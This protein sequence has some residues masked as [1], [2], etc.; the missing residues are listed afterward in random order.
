MTIKTQIIGVAIIIVSLVVL[1][2]QNPVKK[3]TLARLQILDITE[4]Y[5]EVRAGEHVGRLYNEFV[6]DFSETDF[7]DWFGVAGWSGIALRS[8]ASPTAIAGA[9]LSEDII[10]DDADFIDNQITADGG[11]ARFAASDPVG[12]NA[13]SIVALENATMWFIKGDDLW[14]RAR[15]LIEFGQPNALVIFSD[16]S[17]EGSP[18]VKISVNDGGFIGVAPNTGDKAGLSQSN[19]EMPRGRWFNLTVHLVLHNRSG[20]VQVW[21]DDLLVL[22][23]TMKTLPTK[24]ALLNAF[25]I[26]ISA[27]DAAAEILVD[28]VML[29]H[30]AF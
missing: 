13:H 6:F 29:S 24:G 18:G 15:F 14:F 22:E 11:A 17:S 25:Q 16:N 3:D 27:A 23:G 20:Q 26:G 10:N 28:D 30:D 12:E 5:V 4:A 1:F 8:H 2:I 19:V 9:Q 7:R 21:Q